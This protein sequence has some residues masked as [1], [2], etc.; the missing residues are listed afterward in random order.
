MLDYLLAHYY[1]YKAQEEVMCKEFSRRK[2][3]AR[4]LYWNACKYP[5]KKKKS[6]RKQAL[7]DFQLYS[8]LEQPVIFY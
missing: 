7:S 4:K 8:I 5:R 6:L 3:E 1:E 2:E